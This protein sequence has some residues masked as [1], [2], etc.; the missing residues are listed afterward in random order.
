MLSIFFLLLSVL[1]FF[2]NLLFHEKDFTERQCIFNLDF[3]RKRI[4][5]DHYLNGYIKVEFLLFFI[6]SSFIVYFANKKKILNYEIINIFFILFLACVFSPVIFIVFSNKACVLYHFNNAIFVWAFLFS[7]IYFIT[8][9]KHF[10][11]IELNIYTCRIF[12]V[13]I[14]FFYCLNTYIEKDN[15]YNNQI[16]KEK[17]IEFQKIT[18]LINDNVIISNST[19]MT[20]DSELMIW[21]IFNDVKYLNLI[22]SAF[23]P[24]TDLMI[25][26]D[27]INSFRFLNLNVHDLKY[28]LRNR[29][30]GWRYLN[31]NVVNFFMYKYQANSLTTFNNSKNFDV[32]VAKFIF[33]SSP[34]YTQQIAIPNEEFIRLE[35]KFNKT[36][37]QN[38][39]EPEIIVLEKL[40]PIT[41]NIVIKKNNYCKLYDGNIYILY[42]KKNSEIKCDS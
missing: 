32:E 42:F 37:L 19:L 23:S 28:F 9:M 33:A 35:K 34:L 13:I 14:T 22:H 21:A 12:F 29:K 40:R 25:E 8:I 27:L 11:K 36:R 10:F 26:N 24:K 18:T 7:I 41:K 3:E 1:P 31:R 6:V 15:K 20:F 4:L 38:F 16:V 17:R 30:E 39:N 2:L 5:L